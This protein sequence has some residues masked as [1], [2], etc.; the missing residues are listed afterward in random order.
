MRAAGATL[1]HVVVRGANAA[2]AAGAHVAPDA[3]ARQVLARRG[4][5]GLDLLPVALELF[6][7]Q[8]G[9]ARQRAL[10]HLGAGNADDDIVV[11]LDEDPGADLVA[12][13]A[14]LSQRA[15]QAGH[16]EAQ[17]K[18]TTGGRAGDQE[19]AARDVFASCCC[20][21]RHDASPQA[22]LPLMDAALVLPA[23]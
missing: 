22:L 15:A 11:G 23:A 8:L 2:A 7:H 4:I 16:V 12:L 21:C 20:C 9:E 3:V 6:R 17:G 1:A 13:G 18:P 19:I 5:F 10:A 14:E